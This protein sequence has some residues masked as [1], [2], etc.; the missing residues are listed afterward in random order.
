MRERKYKTGLG[1]LIQRT[2]KVCFSRIAGD[3]ETSEVVFVVFYMVFQDLPSIQSRCFRTTDSS[4]SMA[5]A[6][7]YLLGTSCRVDIFH[8]SQV[9]VLPQKFAAL[10]ECHRMGMY[11]PD[12]VPVVIR[13]ATD[14]MADMQ[15]MLTHHCSTAVTQQFIVVE[16]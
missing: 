2:E 4:P 13:Q 12:G 6:I 3:K 14:T 15:L 1:G 10:H 8:H 16:Q 7:G 11:F 9:W 5:F